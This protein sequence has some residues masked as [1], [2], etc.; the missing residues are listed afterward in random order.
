MGQA[1]ERRSIPRSRLLGAVELCYLED[2]S[3]PPFGAGSCSHSSCDSRGRGRLC[4]WLPPHPPA[5]NP[6]IPPPPPPL[7]RKL[8]LKRR[9]LP[10]PRGTRWPGGADVS[11]RE[12][13]RRD[14]PRSCHRA[15]PLE[16]GAW[17]SLAG[18][19]HDPSV[20]VPPHQRRQNTLRPNQ[21]LLPMSIVCRVL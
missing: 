7:Q 12:R 2:A 1:R 6:G 16:V 8:R 17:W 3:L 19:G 15:G 4:P 10:R 21:E 14:S 5:G 13:S 20:Q 18:W 9:S 11:L